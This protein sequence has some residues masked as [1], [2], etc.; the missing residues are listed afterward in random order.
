MYLMKCGHVVSTKIDETQPICLVCDCIDVEREI[1]SDAE[2][3]DILKGR[4]AICSSHKYSENKPVDSKWTLP[5]FE[6]CPDEEYD[7]YYCGCYGWD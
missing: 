1:I 7:K 4:K 3:D 5:F 6:Y 2:L